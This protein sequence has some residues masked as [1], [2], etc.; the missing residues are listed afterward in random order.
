MLRK[1]IVESIGMET[2]DAKIDRPIMMAARPK[3]LSLV[4]EAGMDWSRY[5]AEGSDSKKRLSLWCRYGSAYVSKRWAFRPM[6]Q[7]ANQGRGI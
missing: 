5:T 6:V 1:W 3:R 2:T 7:L 4:V